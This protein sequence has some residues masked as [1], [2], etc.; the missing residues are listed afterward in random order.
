MRFPSLCLLAILSLSLPSSRVFAADKWV[1]A[2]SAHFDMYT[3]ESEN[4]ARAT[5][6]HLEAVRAFFVN[7]T[8]SQ[9]PN[10]QPVRVVAFH[11]ES[12]FYKYKPAEYSLV[13]AY[14][15]PGPPATIVSRGLKP[16][17]YESIFLE[18]CQ[19]ALDRSA[20]QFPFWIRAGLAQLYSTLKPGEGTMRLGDPPTRPY[21]AGT[22]SINM[23]TL[24]A[25]DRKA[26]LES[27]ARVANNFD[28]DTDN[29]AALGKKAPASSELN[30]S[31][32]DFQDYQVDTWMLTHMVMFGRDYRAKAGQFTSALANRQDTA[33][34]FNTVY[35]R[36]LQQVLEDMRLYMKQAGLPVMN[37]K[38]VYDK[39]AAP[40][41]QVMTKQDQDTLMAALGKK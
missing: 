14:S 20:S 19:M 31:Q 12:D 10:G 35:G 7:A 23:T 33:T 26:Y 16:D 9:D 22:G 37:A 38:F 41:I 3:D 13:T 18:Y 2:T 36:S 32:G 15:L 29:S 30:A 24:V 28:S 25:I 1:H 39:P 21:A 40:Q 11:S 4:E 8:H 34:A 5:L 6:Q 17:R 27:K